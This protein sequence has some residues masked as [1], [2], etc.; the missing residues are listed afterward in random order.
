MNSLWMQL[1]AQQACCGNIHFVKYYKASP[2]GKGPKH[3]KLL[4]LKH[5]KK[6]TEKACK[7]L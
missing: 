7:S 6:P 3:T 2:V 1:R 5:H 4:V